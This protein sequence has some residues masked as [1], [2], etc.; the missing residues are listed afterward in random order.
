[1][2]QGEFPQFSDSAASNGEFN[3]KLAVGLFSATASQSA[4]LSLSTRLLAEAT[5]DFKLTSDWQ[6]VNFLS[7]PSWHLP[8]PPTSLYTPPL[9]LHP[10]P[11]L[12]PG[13]R[14]FHFHVAPCWRGS[15]STAV[16]RHEIQM[17]RAN[18]RTCAARADSPLIGHYSR[19]KLVFLA[20]LDLK[21]LSN[22]LPTG[23][24]IFPNQ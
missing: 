17:M 15:V 7:S 22:A 13:P 8:T 2:Q 24:Q 16:R 14:L 18:H 12:A 6:S 19:P 1:M 23:L 3:L 4:L 9:L 5:G 21:R 10:L 20:A 11:P